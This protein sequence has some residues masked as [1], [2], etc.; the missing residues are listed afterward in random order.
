MASTP[1]DIAV[2]SDTASVASTASTASTASEAAPS[3]T[4]K[5]FFQSD[6]TLVTLIDG[7]SQGP[8]AATGES[9]PFF[10]ENTKIFTPASD[11]EFHP[12]LVRSAFSLYNLL[13]RTAAMLGADMEGLLPN[14]VRK[15]FLRDFILYMARDVLG[16]VPF[17]HLLVNGL[18]MAVGRANP[19]CTLLRDAARIMFC[20]VGCGQLLRIKDNDVSKRNHGWDVHYVA[21]A[22]H[23]KMTSAQGE[24]A[25]ELGKE[26]QTPDGIEL[27]QKLENLGLKNESE[28]LTWTRINLAFNKEGYDA[29]TVWKHLDSQYLQTLSAP[30]L[31]EAQKTEQ[32]NYLNFLKAG[33]QATAAV[34]NFCADPAHHV[35][36]SNLMTQHYEK[37]LELE[38][39]VHS[40]THLVATITA[41]KNALR[42]KL[43]KEVTDG[44]DEKDI[45]RFAKAAAA[46][47]E[48]CDSNSLLPPDG[49]R[50]SVHEVRQV[51]LLL[52]IPLKYSQW[53]HLFKEIEL[54][55]G[56]RIFEGHAGSTNMLVS[57]MYVAV[58]WVI[59]RVA[60]DWE[61][62]RKE[63]KKQA[64]SSAQ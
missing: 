17:P 47:I 24:E 10:R 20:S 30:E 55:T 33:C 34:L 39:A 2:T 4:Y 8:Q 25:A 27:L 6:P 18:E 7:C 53:E 50:Y 21:S 13:A 26:L 38:G 28:D 1:T 62:A 15:N 31:S 44:V 48:F 57:D 5:P 52:T 29:R 37:R 41:E 3:T 35:R 32:T 63:A 60:Q 58:A 64:E 59:Q 46:V 42:E 36:V 23:T 16:S 56:L 61:D 9:V 11:R 12:E 49:T 54:V 51:Q 45:P 40:Q 19:A 14:D 22:L 43:L